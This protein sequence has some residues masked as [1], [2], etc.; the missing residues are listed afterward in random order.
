MFECF[1]NTI[2]CKFLNLF[3]VPRPL[4]YV[5]D[6]GFNL[7]HQTSN[8]P[9]RQVAASLSRVFLR[10]PACPEQAKRVDGCPRVSVSNDLSPMLPSSH[11]PMPFL[12]PRFPVSPPQAFSPPPPLS[13]SPP[14]MLDFPRVTASPRPRV[15]WFLHLLIFS[16]VLRAAFCVLFKT[17]RNV[18]TYGSP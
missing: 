1:W 18:S 2:S 6:A 10:V 4:S 15:I 8:H 11:A 14:P 3:C 17:T 12:H 13:R 9:F 16:C 7:K 5:S